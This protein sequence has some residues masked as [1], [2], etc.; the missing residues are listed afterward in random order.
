MG[1]KSA[2]RPCTLRLAWLPPPPP[3][4]SGDADNE[5]PRRLPSISPARVMRFGM[6]NAASE[7]EEEEEGGGGMMLSFRDTG[8]GDE[9]KADANCQ[10]LG[11]ERG[12]RWVNVD[13]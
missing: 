5:A 11:R 12:G 4:R 1:N 7:E 8:G 3:P 6:A 13:E 10:T 2:K 9:D